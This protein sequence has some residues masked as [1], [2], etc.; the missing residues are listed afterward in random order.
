MHGVKAVHSAGLDQLRGQTATAWRLEF[1]TASVCSMRRKTS[2][3]T[4]V[5]GSAKGDQTLNGFVINYSNTKK[6][7]A[8]MCQATM[9]ETRGEVARSWRKALTRRICPV[10]TGAIVNAVHH[11]D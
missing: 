2:G 1:T 9:D 8:R 4:T 10:T 6:L 11:Y 7:S 5:N 3:V